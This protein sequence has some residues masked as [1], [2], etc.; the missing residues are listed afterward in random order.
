M[1]FSQRRAT[2]LHYVA[3]V[4]CLQRSAPLASVVDAGAAHHRR[5]RP[6]V[7]PSRLACHAIAAG[8]E[9][10][11]VRACDCLLQHV[12]AWSAELKHN[13]ARAFI[14][15]PHNSRPSRGCSSN[16]RGQRFCA[17]LRLSDVPNFVISILAIALAAR[18]QVSVMHQ[19]GGIAIRCKRRWRCIQRRASCRP[20]AAT[21]HHV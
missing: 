4:C 16:S 20:N 10:L 11:V 13:V 14:R 12:A 5:M 19:V 7:T 6:G 2:R 1:L 21:Q 9:Q 15:R 3:F 8:P 17:W 18:C